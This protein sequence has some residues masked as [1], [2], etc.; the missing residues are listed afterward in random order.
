MNTQKLNLHQKILKIADAARILQK[1]KAGYNFKYVPEEEIQAKITP[2][3]DNLGVVLY[4]KTVPGT[5]KITPISYTKKKGKDDVTV[6]E[7]IVNSDVIYT[8]VNAENPEEQMEVPWVFVG[9]M[10]DASQAFGA[11]ATYCNRYFLMKTL[12]LA[13]SESDL[14]SFRS[15]QKEAEKYIEEKEKTEELKKA[16]T[17]VIEIG[18]ALLGSDKITQANLSATI[19]KHN[20]NEG[21]PNKIKNKKVAN[22]IIKE[23]KQLLNKEEK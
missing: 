18:T 2:I 4:C 16:I 10:E 19:A 1:N 11:G 21:N 5:L 6:N 9:Q 13:T 15:K 22:A 23:L 12:Q 7:V 14:D 17:E 20:D 8:W 3:I